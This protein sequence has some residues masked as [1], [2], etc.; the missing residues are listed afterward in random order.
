MLLPNLRIRND[1]SRIFGYFC[2]RYVF[3]GLFPVRA[4][5]SYKSGGGPS[6][7][8]DLGLLEQG[9]RLGLDNLPS[10]YFQPIT[11]RIYQ[12]MT[13]HRSVFCKTEEKY[14]IFYG[15]SRNRFFC[16]AVSALWWV[17][18]AAARHLSTDYCVSIISD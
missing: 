6:G 17:G 12:K 13:N 10:T 9:L 4:R 16:A 15:Q 8:W 3:L 1:K 11:A 18:R 14:L 2:Q 5:Q 7:P